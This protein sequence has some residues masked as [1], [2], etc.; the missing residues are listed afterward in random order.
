MAPRA[1]IRIVGTSAGAAALLSFGIAWALIARFYEQ[2]VDWV[3]RLLLTGTLL[4]AIA[5]GCGIYGL[6]SRYL[7]R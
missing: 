1:M 2:H 6:I 5:L 4:A 7:K 3:N